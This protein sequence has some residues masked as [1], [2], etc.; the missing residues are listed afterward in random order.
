ME[1]RKYSE[2]SWKKPLAP[3]DMAQPSMYGPENT[4]TGKD[5]GGA[6]G[7]EHSKHSNRLGGKKYSGHGPE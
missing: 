6:T 3:R 5:S 7:C 1:D 4:Q 2:K